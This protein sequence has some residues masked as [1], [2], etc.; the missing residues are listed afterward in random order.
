MTMRLAW[1]NLTFGNA[2]GYGVAGWHMAQ[3]TLAAAR[4][5]GAVSTSE[6]ALAWDAMVM[7]GLPQ[8]WP[9]YPGEMRPDLIWHT[10]LEV[11]RLPAGWVE[12]LNRC[13][14]VWAPSTWVK[15]LFEWHGVWKPIVVAGYGI[16]PNVFWPK[17]DET[18]KGGGPMRFGVWVDALR[19]RKH[20]EMAVDAWLAAGVP[21]ATLEV[22]LTDGTAAPFWVDGKG[23]PHPDI[24]VFRGEWPPAKV[25]DWLRSLD[26]LIYLSGG[27]GFGLMPLEAMACGTPVVC[28]Y[29][30]G[31]MD[32]LTPDNAVLVKEHTPEPATTYTA[33]F[34]FD[35]EPMQLRPD[36]DEAVSAIRWASEHRDRSLPAIGVRAAAD[37]GRMTWAEAGKRAW[38]AI[39]GSGA[40]AGAAGGA[41]AGAAGGAVA[42]AAGGQQVAG[43]RQPMPAFEREEWWA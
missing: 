34:E 6:F 43:S 1:V 25:A 29:N 16:D 17:R 28:A 39:A 32:Y 4:Q 21:E 20:A 23:H 7:F 27:E 8:T 41:V 35:H 10:M 9:F 14:L 33:R 38:D 26:C 24:K 31:M 15:D 13:G 42:G 3:A 36:F 40:V 12:I 22:K 30:T 18:R 2:N 5:S 19:T 11:D 37:A